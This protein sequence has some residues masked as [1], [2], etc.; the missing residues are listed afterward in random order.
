MP[1]DFHWLTA[2]VLAVGRVCC[3]GRCVSVLEGGYGSWKKL[4]SPVVP[5][6]AVA[7][8]ALPTAPRLPP[9]LRRE[10]LADCCAAHLRALV[11]DGAC[12][13]TDGVRSDAIADVWAPE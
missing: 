6:A 4:Q 9:V 3:P 13:D 1:S 5:H 2:Q 11:D 7:T 12:L 10:N 8:A